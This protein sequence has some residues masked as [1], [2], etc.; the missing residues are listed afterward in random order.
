MTAQLSRLID[1][2]FKRLVCRR[3]TISE[4]LEAEG[5]LIWQ[6]D[7]WQMTKTGEALVDAWLIPLAHAIFPNDVPKA[8]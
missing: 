5:H 4:A 2:Y 7:R 8:R 3:C 1:I 6:N